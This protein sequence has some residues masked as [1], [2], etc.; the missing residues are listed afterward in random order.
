[1]DTE[2]E[3]EFTVNTELFSMLKK[4]NITAIRCP[5]CNSDI[6]GIVQHKNNNNMISQQIH[7]RCN[8]C[9]QNIVV[10]LLNSSKLDT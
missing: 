7:A 6:I 9:D 4:L 1:M 2:P 10:L 5:R 3:C 8:N